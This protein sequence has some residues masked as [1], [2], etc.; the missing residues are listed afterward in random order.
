MIHMTIWA[1]LYC[2]VGTA[3]LIIAEPHVW[4]ES[5]IAQEEEEEEEAWRLSELALFFFAQFGD[6]LF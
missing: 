4:M 5:F 3:L 6:G 2:S 1:F